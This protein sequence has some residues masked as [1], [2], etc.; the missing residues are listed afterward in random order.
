[1][2][3]YLKSNTIVI[4]YRGAEVGTSDWV[5]DG[6]SQSGEIAK[7]Y[8]NALVLVDRYL[9]D[10]PNKNII[11]TGYSLGGA[12]STYAGLSRSLEVYNFNPLSLNQRS[13]D[14]IKEL[15]LANGC[16]DLEFTKRTKKI[17]NYAFP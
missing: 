1:M 9:S 14:L 7:Q 8:D 5:T 3:R 6:I 13:I 17:T 4:A 11:L 12:L 10:F 16:K 2:L 15:L